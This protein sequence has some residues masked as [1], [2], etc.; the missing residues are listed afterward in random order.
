M[1]PLEPEPMAHLYRSDPVVVPPQEFVGQEKMVRRLFKAIAKNHCVSLRGTHLSGKSSLLAY[2]ASAEGQQSLPSDC[3]LQRHILIP[4]NLQTYRQ[5]ARDDFFHE[6]YQLIARQLDGLS[7]LRDKAI[8]VEYNGVQKIPK[9][10][11]MHAESYKAQD[12]FE[13]VLKRSMAQRYRPVLLLDAFDNVTL[14]DQFDL[15]FFGLLRAKAIKDQ[16]SYVTASV[17]PLNEVCHSSIRQSPFF[18]I[19]HSCDLGP[20]TLAEAHTLITKRAS[21]TPYVFS[22]VEIEWILS[23]AGKHPFFI[24]YLCH[25]LF[26][27]K[28]QQSRKTIELE[29]LVPEVYTGLQPHF[30]VIWNGLSDRQRH[31]LSTEDQQPELTVL[32]EGSLFRQFVAQRQ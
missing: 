20:L 14:N 23:H 6:V 18:N 25:T 19:F 13:D 17:A 29:Q 21:Q 2:I 24:E 4:I 12:L 10:T 5:K 30:H 8:S 28:M 16:V 1:S 26:M 9:Q 22:D 3:D 11:S 15:E 27:K 7:E 31:Q 32:S